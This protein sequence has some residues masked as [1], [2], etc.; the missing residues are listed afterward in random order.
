MTAQDVTLSGMTYTAPRYKRDEVNKAGQMLLNPPMLNADAIE[1]MLAVINNWRA[2]HNFPLN[3]FHVTLR[4]RARKLDRHAIT[5]Q[6]L[7]RLSS[8]RTK[9]ARQPDMKLT[10]MQ[11]I[12]GCR[13]VLRD[14]KTVNALIAS[15]QKS[16]RKNP[17]SR[18]EFLHAKDYI[19]NPKPDGYRSTHLVYR[20]RT[21]S[22]H[23]QTYEGLKV[24][25]Q[26]RT[27]VQHAWATALETVDFFSQQAL[28]TG[29][30]EKD[31]R[32]F[33]ALVS[34]LFAV[35]EGTPPV[36]G[37]PTDELELVTEIQALQTSLKVINTL[38]VWRA[39]VGLDLSLTTTPN[40]AYYVLKL[41]TDEAGLEVF[42]FTAAEF[43]KATAKLAELEAAT[44]EKEWAHAVLVSVKSASELKQAYPN[45]YADTEMFVTEMISAIEFAIQAAQRKISAANSM[46]RS[47]QT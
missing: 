15:Y 41:D 2:A 25:I 21:S 6:R 22:V 8:I 35:K 14:I 34:T 12:G 32:R 36:P 3:T 39:A 26:I 46:S 20:Y 33:F 28:K 43:D 16:V 4:N 30:G 45:Y 37:T 29:G 10:Q 9:L 5:A 40:A 27:K 1:H 13:A 11:D 42:G 24:E 23:R 47:V 18:S 31:W 44:R 7:K 19:A 17:S 38:N